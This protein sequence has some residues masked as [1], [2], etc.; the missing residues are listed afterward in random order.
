MDARELHLWQLQCLVIRFVQEPP[1]HKNLRKVALFRLLGLVDGM[2]AE[3]N[4]RYL[5]RRAEWYFTL[6]ELLDPDS[7]NPIFI[8]NNQKLIA[9]LSS[10]KWKIN[11][12]GLIQIES[13]EDMKKRG[14][15]SPDEADAVV[16]AMSMQ[17]R[18][19]FFFV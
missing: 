5:N 10:I 3:N 6:R 13:K 17:R 16:M 4:E 18:L 7:D 1:V 12:R 15:K 14:V 11:S 2:R 8:P 19:D 9:Q